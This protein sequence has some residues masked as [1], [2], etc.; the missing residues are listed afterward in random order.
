MS[1]CSKD[2]KSNLKDAYV[3]YV[4]GIWYCYKNKKHVCAIS[5]TN[6]NYAR[7]DYTNM[8]K[9]FKDDY[10]WIMFVTVFQEIK[11]CSEGQFQPSHRILQIYGN[12]PID[13]LFGEYNE[14]TSAFDM[15]F[16]EPI[17]TSED[18]PFSDA[19]VYAKK[20]DTKLDLSYRNYIAEFKFDNK[21]Y[22]VL[23]DMG[24]GFWN[25]SHLINKDD[26]IIVHRTKS[27]ENKED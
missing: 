7:S 14:M 16:G 13:R 20:S 25:F 23:F 1:E 15:V 17:A 10:D 27:K 11:K 22:A 6:F 3:S 21:K 8:S 24:N 2:L 18:N 19:F 4:W 12:P 9:Q 26:V 5:Y